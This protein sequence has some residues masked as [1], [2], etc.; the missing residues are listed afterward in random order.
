[1]LQCLQA[2]DI[3]ELIIKKNARVY[4]HFFLLYNLGKVVK[5]AIAMSMLLYYK[6]LHQPKFYN[7]NST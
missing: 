3:V 4:G 2:T 1:M 5:E 6:L 7:K